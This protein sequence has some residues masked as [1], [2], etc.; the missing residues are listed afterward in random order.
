MSKIGAKIRALSS[1]GFLEYFLKTDPVGQNSSPSVVFMY[2][3]QKSVFQ[4]IRKN[5]ECYNID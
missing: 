5:Y 4:L 3:H 1:I 2:I